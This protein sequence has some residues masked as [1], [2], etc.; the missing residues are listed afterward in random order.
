M[1]KYVG[2]GWVQGVP[3]QDISEETY[4]QAIRDGHIVEG[5]PSSKIYKKEKE[6]DKTERGGEE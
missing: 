3:A 2:P 5:E 1:R 6:K 4:Q